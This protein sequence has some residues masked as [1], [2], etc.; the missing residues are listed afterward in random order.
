[1]PRFELE[2]GRKQGL[3]GDKS[4]LPICPE[5]WWRECALLTRK[6][7]TGQLLLPLWDSPGIS[8][9]SLVD[10]RRLFLILGWF[11]SWLF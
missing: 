10:I 7:Q 3:P 2:I 6:P 9:V 11:P 4:A 1:M 5:A 8:L